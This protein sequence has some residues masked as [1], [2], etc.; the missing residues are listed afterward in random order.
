MRPTRLRSAVTWLPCI[1]R[2]EEPAEAEAYLLQAAKEDPA[3]ELELAQFYVLQGDEDHG[4]EAAGRAVDFHRKLLDT[5]RHNDGVRIRAAKALL[6]AKD[7]S[8]T[9][10]LLEEGY[11][12]AN[13]PGYAGMLSEAYLAWWAEIDAQPNK[14]PDETSSE[15]LDRLRQAL[16]YDPWNR[17]AI[18]RLLAATHGS[19]PMVTPAR[20]IAAPMLAVGDAPATAHL[21]LG[22]DALQQGESALGRRHLEQAYE[23]DPRSVEITNNLAWSLAHSDPPDLPRAKELVD[24]AVKAD[25]KRLP[26]RDTRGRILAEMGEWKSALADLEQC[27][28]LMKDDPE[29]HDI[30]A[31]AY[32]HQGLDDMASEHERLARRLRSGPKTPLP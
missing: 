7:F 3:L 15:Q 2:L 6:L 5:N 29:F 12:Q 8:D 19:T 14:S 1:S 21:L 28:L 17:T 18:L 22:T 23:L 32:E 31:Q 26:L 9:V 20:R 25:P 24:A 10:A 11:R 4:V 27:L 16:R 30:V 13:H